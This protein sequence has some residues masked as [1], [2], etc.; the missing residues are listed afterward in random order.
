MFFYPKK[1]QKSDLP[2][3]FLNIV[4]NVFRANIVDLNIY[5]N[6]EYSWRYARLE[7]VFHSKKMQN[8]G[9]QNYLFPTP[10]R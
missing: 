10:L 6:P 7:K 9:L 5:T 1:A 8:I 4:K 3:F 2:L